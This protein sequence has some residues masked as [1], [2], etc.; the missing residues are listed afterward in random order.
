[1]VH[2]FPSN[3]RMHYGTGSSWLRHN[4][5][6]ESWSVADI[7][8]MLERGEPFWAPAF[9]VACARND[10]DH[11][12]TKPKHPWTTDVMDKLFLGEPCYFSSAQGR[13]RG[14]VQGVRM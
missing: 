14:Q 7:K 4:P 11:R 12:L 3:G 5:K 13:P 2:C 9:E 10:I 8:G 1:M 6:G